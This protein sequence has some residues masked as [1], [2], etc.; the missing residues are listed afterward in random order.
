MRKYLQFFTYYILLLALYWF[1]I[2]VKGLSFGGG[3]LLDFLRILEWL[4]FSPKICNFGGY[5]YMVNLLGFL[6]I[7]R[8][9]YSRFLQKKNSTK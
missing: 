5:Q 1:G 7:G 8:L 6:V 2:M 3:G 9:L 4:P